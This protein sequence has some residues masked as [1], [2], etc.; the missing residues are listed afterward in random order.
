MEAV[1]RLPFESQKLIW[2]QLAEKARISAL[3]PQEHELYEESWLN[4][5]TNMNVLETAKEEGLAEGR[6]KG[7]AESRINI[8][9][10]LKSIGMAVDV[11]MHVTGLS[12]E[13]IEAL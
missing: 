8:A 13:D 7:L 6:E 9:R 10:N 11:I 1:E 12:Q 4:Y 2:Q 3:T 5:C